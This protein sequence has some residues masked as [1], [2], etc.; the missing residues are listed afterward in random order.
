M[1]RFRF[2]VAGPKDDLE[3]RQLLAVTPMAGPVTLSFR[4]EP[5]FFAAAVVDGEF[6]QTV[7]ARDT[8]ENRIAALGIR[9]VRQRYVNGMPMAVGYLSGLRVLPRYRGGRILAEGYR[10][11]KSLHED[12]RAKFYLTTIAEGNTAALSALTSARAGLPRYHFAGRYYTFA[13]PLSAGR[14]ECDKGNR[15]VQIRHGTSADLPAVTRYL[16]AVGATRQFFPRYDATDFF[17]HRGT[18]RDLRAEDLLLATR[19]GEIV[20]M[21]AC[22]DQTAFRQIVVEE[23]APSIRL[24]RPLFNG[25]AALARQP[26]LPKAGMTLEFLTGALFVVRE[27][28]PHVASML[29]QSAGRTAANRTEHILI[30]VHESDPL[31]AVVR[32]FKSAEYVTRLYC[33]CWDDGEEMRRSLDDRPPYLELGCL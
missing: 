2:E 15:A 13:V 5:S 11:L 10:F 32:R 25:W 18:F 17:D 23:Y 21:L 31:A 8:G 26:K 27:N 9:S 29:L 6:H 20:G 12:G 24:T 16:S 19:S 1:S 14:R 7:I 22:W 3:L 4:R 28:D 33:V 30:G